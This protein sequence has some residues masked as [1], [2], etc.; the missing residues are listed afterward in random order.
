[1]GWCME[2]ISLGIAA[3]AL[4]AS[5]FG[6]GFAK[7][8]GESAWDAVK[9]LKAAIFAR[10]QADSD[11]Q[12]AVAA[13]VETPTPETQSEVAERITAAA[14]A[15]SGFAAELARLVSLARKDKTVDGFVATAFDNAKQVNIGGDNFG[16]I[17]L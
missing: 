4:L 8:A 13:L 10:F 3:A 15:D 9:R 17:N 7:D 14:R 6:E 16:P 11:A 12:R 1:M 2:P 5:K